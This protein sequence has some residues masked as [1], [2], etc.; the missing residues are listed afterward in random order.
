MKLIRID[1]EVWAALQKRA[2]AFDDT[3]NSVLRRILK[4]EGAQENQRTRARVARGAKTPPSAYRAAILRA[5]YEA[6]GSAPVSQ[7]LE[8]VYALM[9]SRFNETDRQ[10]LPTGQVRWRNTAQW[11]RHAMVQEGLL[12]KDSPRGLWELTAKGIAAAESML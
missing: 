5:L 11:E 6:G 7:V 10:T 12:K 4:L 3:P 2:R 8:R 1:D 9:E